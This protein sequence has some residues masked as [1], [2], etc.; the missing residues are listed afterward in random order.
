M[1]AGGGCPG[2]AWRGRTGSGGGEVTQNEVP[3]NEN[4]S[5]NIR[6]RAFFMFFLQYKMTYS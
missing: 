6:S 4:D 2:T 1:P 3:T 5:R